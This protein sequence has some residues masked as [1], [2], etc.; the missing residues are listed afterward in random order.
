MEELRQRASGSRAQEENITAAAI[1]QLQVAFE[2]LQ[3]ADEE[4]RQQNEEL[5]AA[6]EGLEL[7]RQRYMDLFD[8]APDGYLVTDPIGAISEANFAA[9]RLCGVAPKFLVGKPLSVFVAEEQ[10]DAFRSQL[11]RVS[12]L[13]ADC[14][15]EFEIRM[16]RRQGEAFEAA[17]KVTAVTRPS[18]E[19]TA[20]RWLIR[21]I[22][23][24]KRTEEQIRQINAELERRV[25]ERTAE[26]QIANKVKD[27]LLV[28]EQ[29]ARRDAETANRSKD[30]FL[31]TLGHE[32]RTPLNAIVGWT[33]ILSAQPRV[34]K[35]IDQA[36]EVIKRNALAQSQ[37][38]NDILDVSRITTGN[39]NLEQ[40]QISFSRIVEVVL[41][42]LHPAADAKSIQIESTLAPSSRPVS[43]DSVR[44]QQ[45]VWNLITNAIKFTPN[46]GR[47]EINLEHQDRVRLT[48]S[49]NGEGISPEFLPHVFD[50]FWQADLASS[51]K[52]GGLGLGLSIVRHIVEMHGGTVRATSPGNGQGA[53]FVV[54]LPFAEESTDHA[55]PSSNSG[56]QRAVDDK[57]LG[58]IWVVAVD[59]DPDVRE[60]LKV[61]LQKAGARVTS[62][63]C[64][65]EA[66]VAVKGALNSEPDSS[67]LS[68]TILPDLLVADIAMPD[69]DGFDL[70]GKVRT[71][72]PEEGGTI[73]AIALTAYAGSEDRSRALAEGY[74]AHLSKPVA[75]AELVAV[76]A[77][78]TKN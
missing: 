51:R 72:P 41:E 76:A 66:I 42:A 68:R 61:S 44:L 69:E 29:Q 33:H 2:E 54:T 58:G 1:E 8:A 78:L 59:D 22:T 23:E 19:V 60:L 71:L 46:G 16:R 13:G 65:A 4:L 75:P 50:R 18:G 3:V 53:T 35:L 32:L 31:A 30:E 26:L 20:L 74:Q 34:E 14:D 6:R 77:R 63:S 64:C 17:I 67:G 36:V 62:A 48:V 70:I 10:H 27:D 21:D 52:H 47:I 56:D 49:D 25:S 45:V 28:R 43:G 9:G 11:H 40:K 12:L 5:Q 15:K 57:A 24:R 55:T 73:P 7:Q 38:V 39:L 37:I